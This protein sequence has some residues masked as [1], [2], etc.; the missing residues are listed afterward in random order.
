[1]GADKIYEILIANA[2]PSP[3]PGNPP[4]PCEG[5]QSDQDDQSGQSGQSNSPQDGEDEEDDDSQTEGNSNQ[6]QDDDADNQSGDETDDA[7]GQGDGDADDQ[8][9]QPQFEDQ[10]GNGGFLPYPSEDP[11]ELREAEQ[12]AEIKTIQANNIAKACGKES[13][14]ARR[15]VQSVLETK[16]DPSDVL[17]EFMEESVCREDY[18]WLPP[19]RYNSNPDIILPDLNEGE[20]RPNVLFAVDTSGSISDD[21]LKF[22][23]DWISSVLEEYAVNFIVCY[24]STWVDDNETHEVGPEDLPVKL[25]SDHSGGTRFSP[26]FKYY[27]DKGFDVKAILYFTDL[28]CCDF[29]EAP[30][31]PVVWMCTYEPNKDREVPFGKVIYW[32]LEKYERNKNRHRHCRITERAK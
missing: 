21:E 22:Y 31:V 8:N 25:R 9:A 6:T 17:R 29:G 2:P 1:M 23:A 32:D 3:G 19:S 10:G 11:T 16:L 14:T 7:D 12:D 30:D 5:G 13:I 4:P 18:G 26:V 20:D 28:C 27:K 24:C 15:I